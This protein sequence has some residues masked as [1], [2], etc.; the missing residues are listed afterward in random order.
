MNL[1]N[2][3]GLSM[4]TSQRNTLPGVRSNRRHMPCSPLLEDVDAKP[5]Y[6]SHFHFFG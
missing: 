6:W 3:S 1:A 4:V 2:L 5:R